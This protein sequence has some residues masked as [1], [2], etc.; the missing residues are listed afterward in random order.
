MASKTTI[1][2]ETSDLQLSSQDVHKGVLQVLLKAEELITI[3]TPFKEKKWLTE[4]AP[5]KRK[6]GKR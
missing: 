3:K 6:K 5:K 4:R 2:E 1:M